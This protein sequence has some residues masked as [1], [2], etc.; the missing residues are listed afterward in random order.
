MQKLIVKPEKSCNFAFV[1]RHGCRKRVVMQGKI[2]QINY[3]I[4]QQYESVRN[5]FHFNSRFV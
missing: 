2:K 1:L 3:L 4:N 5:R